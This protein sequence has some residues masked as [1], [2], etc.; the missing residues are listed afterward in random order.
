MI[1]SHTNCKKYIFTGTTYHGSF[2]SQQHILHHPLSPYGTVTR[3]E[4]LVQD[5]AAATNNSHHSKLLSNHLE[6]LLF[7]LGQHLRHRDE[8]L[9]IRIDFGD[10]LQ[11]TQVGHA[12]VME[13]GQLLGRVRFRRDPGLARIVNGRQLIQ[14][15][16]HPLFVLQYERVHD[17]HVR[18]LQ[19]KMQ[20]KLK[21]LFLSN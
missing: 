11:L 9:D 7:V 21:I 8:S 18:F 16:D 4:Y 17:F 13:R 3:K 2:P 10:R 5:V 12:D 1:E 15:D 20:S 19:K 14:K 6:I